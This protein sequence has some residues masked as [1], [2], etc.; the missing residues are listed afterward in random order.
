MVAFV[1]GNKRK[2]GGH[3]ERHARILPMHSGQW[4]YK[5]YKE[6]ARNE[7]SLAILIGD[8][9]VMYGLKKIKKRMS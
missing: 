3:C 9:T 7:Q 2:I 4:Y 8:K 1:M 6:R 5:Y